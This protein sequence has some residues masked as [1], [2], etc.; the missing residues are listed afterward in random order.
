MADLARAEGLWLHADG[1]YGGTFQLTERGR[2]LL[3]GID[4]ADSITLD[5]HK[6]MFLPYGTGTLLVREGAHLRAAHH[7]GADYLQDI[8]AEERIPSFSEYSPELSRNFRGLRLWLPVKLHGMAAFREALDEKLD[9]ARYLHDELRATPG[10]ELP[11]EPQLT[12]VAFR[13]RPRT[14]DAD[15]FNARLLERINSSQRVVM[16][17]TRL[18]GQFFIRACILSHRTHR[19]RV[20]EAVHI[21]R[22]AAH[23]LEVG[24]G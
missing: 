12:V 17:S 22:A 15:K 14:A 3:T 8:A 4:R 18:R 24:P 5:P 16:S 23:D 19:D 21:V 7:V 10:F 2:A 13:Y 11:W 6:G 20:K 1:A 9:L